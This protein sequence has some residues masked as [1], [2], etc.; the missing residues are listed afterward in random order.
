MKQQ[1]PSPFDQAEPAPGAGVP[2]REESFTRRMLGFGA[3][4][5]RWLVM[6]A[7]LVA[8][9][10]YGHRY[11]LYAQ[12]YEKT[13]NAYVGADTVEIAAEV[14]GPIAAIH[15]RTNQAVRRG[16]PLFE[17]DPDRFR[18]ALEHAQAELEMVR[19][20]L[21]ETDASVAAAQA[22]V[23]ERQAQLRNARAV[24]ARNTA[25]VGRKLLSAQDAENSATSVSTAQAAVAAAQAR[26]REAQVA[27]GRSGDDNASVRAALA[28][29]ARARL[30]LDNTRIASPTTGVVGSLKISRGQ[31]VDAK[32]ALF[33]IINSEKYWV[34]AN[35]K[36][37]QI[38]HMHVGQKARV[39]LDAYPD[40][41]FEGVIDSM[42]GGAG[43]A[44]S[45]LPPQNATGN[46]VKVTQRVP[47]RV[48]ILKPDP[49]LPLRIGTTATVTID[50]H[51]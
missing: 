37:T 5:A 21:Q 6:A 40:H 17:I 41:P 10:V 9:A 3:T 27:L 23:L 4:L 25:L 46:W 44:F 26:L 29:I 35:F 28:D 13:E 43:T 12:R 32:K 20:H 34:D 39:V 50:L 33:V 8:A 31:I 45:L 15:V 47:V 1:E 2:A 14:S 22:T 7:V 30:D 51:S 36:E 38:E 24:H 19:Q 42:S 16:D 18:I 49:R 11:W 48:R